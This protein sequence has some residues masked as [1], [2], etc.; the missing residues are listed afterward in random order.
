MQVLELLKLCIK[1]QCEHIFLLGLL[2]KMGQDL[3]DRQYTQCTDGIVSCAYYCLSKKK[4]PILYSNLLYK[5][6]H[7]FLDTKY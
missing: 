4:L 5:M 3:L 2:N 7:Y 6:G 1:K